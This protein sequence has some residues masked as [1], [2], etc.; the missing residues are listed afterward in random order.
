[1]PDEITINRTRGV[2]DSIM[3]R[4]RMLVDVS[5]RDIS[6]SVLGQRIEIPVMLAPQVN[7]AGPIP[8][9]S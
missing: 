7:M 3:L 6:T 2:F 4:P 1:M 9:G 8:M 5:E